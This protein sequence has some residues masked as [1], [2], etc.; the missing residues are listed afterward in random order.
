MSPDAFR[1]S[2][3]RLMESLKVHQQIL[4]GSWTSKARLAIPKMSAY[5]EFRRLIDEL[6]EFLII[7]SGAEMCHPL[8]NYISWL[9]L[10]T[11][12]SIYQWGNPNNDGV[13]I[14]PLN[15]TKDLSFDTVI[16]GGL[17]DGEFPAVFRSD[18]FLPSKQRGTESDRLREDRLLFYQA[19]TL[20]RKQM[21]LLSPQHDGDIELGA[22]AF[23]DELQ[24]IAE[25]NTPTGG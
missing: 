15:Q 13:C 18:I 12:Q 22:S 6:V 7:E 8:E 21:H 20:Y 9:R 24:R 5:R 3:D 2:F 16:L 1:E 23:I 10:M 14:L 4:K 19:L 11:S 17:V 25:I